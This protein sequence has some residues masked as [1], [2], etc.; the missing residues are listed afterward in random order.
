MSCW[1]IWNIAGWRLA[2]V[3]GGVPFAADPASYR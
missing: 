2:Q 1:R 3:H